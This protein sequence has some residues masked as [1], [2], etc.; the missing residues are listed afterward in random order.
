MV[1]QVQLCVFSAYVRRFSDRAGIRTTDVLSAAMDSGVAFGI[2][3]I[4]FALQY[5]RN[6]SVGANT[7]QKWWG[8]TVFLSTAD[9]QGLPYKT[10]PTGG[11]FG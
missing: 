4:F 3:I 6:G 11:T 1:D 8:N 9:G 10:V 7:V 5:P 2:V